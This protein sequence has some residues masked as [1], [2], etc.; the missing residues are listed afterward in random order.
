MYNIQFLISFGIFHHTLITRFYLINRIL[1]LILGFNW[2]VF[3]G[4]W[5]RW[6]YSIYWNTRNTFR[7]NYCIISFVLNAG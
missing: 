2:K 5:P 4:F 6:E 3:L 7:C 1:I